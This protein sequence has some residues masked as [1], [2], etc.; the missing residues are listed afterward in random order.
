M[1][2]FILSKQWLST[3]LN[4]LKLEFLTDG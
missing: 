2:I 1:V 3:I 4:F